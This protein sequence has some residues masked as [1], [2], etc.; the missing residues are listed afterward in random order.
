MRLS[1]DKCAF[2][3]AVLHAHSTE[4]DGLLE[5]QKVVEYYASRG[6]GVVALTDHERITRVRVK[7]PLVIPGAELA[8]GRGLLG[9]PYHLV[10]LGV[11]DEAVLRMK[12]PQEVIDFV[13]SSDGVVVV[14]HPH[15]SGLTVSDLLSLKGYSAIEI[16][17]TGCEVE[18]SKGYAVAHWDAL[19]SKGVRVWGVAVDD[20]HRYTIPPIDADEGWVVLCLRELSTDEVLRALKEG[21]F[22]SSTGPD[23]IEADLS[24]SSFE[25]AL[26]GARRVYLISRNGKGFSVDSDVVEWI[27]RDRNRALA[28]LSRYGDVELEAEHEG[29]LT[30]LYVRISGVRVELRSRGRWIE[31][32]RVMGLDWDSYARIEVV[33]ELGRRAWLNPLF[34]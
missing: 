9:E 26:R 20:A 31:W 30:K 18:V 29:T 21:R 27:Y 33:D 25:V 12:D 13:R 34:R 24:G 23:V 14:A 6:Y 19:L 7:E 16:F 8:R 2:V 15:W 10:I 22:Y 3:R 4:S 17:N 1:R 11:E 5:P 28:M 32:V